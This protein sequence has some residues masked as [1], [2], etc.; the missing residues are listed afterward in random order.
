MQTSSEA[1]LEALARGDHDAARALLEQSAAAGQANAAVWLALARLRA[2]IGDE[3]GELAALD[4]TLEFEPRNLAALL[5]KG[6]ALWRKDDK[7]SAATFYGA[8]LRLAGSA[9]SVPADV[10]EPL[11]RARAAND[12]LARELEAHIRDTLSKKG[13]AD[14]N[15]PPRFGRALDFMLGRRRIYAQAPRY[16]YYPELVQVEFFERRDFPWVEAIE[17]QTEAIK[18]ELESVIKRPTGFVPYVPA[19]SNRPERQQAGLAGNMSWSA[20]FLKKDGALQPGS[21]LCPKTWA[22]L[23][24]APLT[25][26]PG[27]APSVLFSRLAPGAHIP[28]H[29]GMINTRLICHLPLI[30]PPNCALR[31]GN[32]VRAWSAGELLIFDDTME[33]EAWNRSEQD[34]YVLLFDIWRPDLS[35]QERAAVVALCEAIDSFGAG[36]PV[37]WDA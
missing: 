26:I 34:R 20:F 8:A 6:D 24:Q 9:K 11:R 14:R 29:T 21:D 13:V 12:T 35:D 19:D 15:A 27:R 18:Q 5:A 3:N 1:G 31:V 16:F 22:A 28:P 2:A 37:A 36:R 4:R 33:H 7:R 10:V 30:V 25:Q 17:A 32:E 23:Q